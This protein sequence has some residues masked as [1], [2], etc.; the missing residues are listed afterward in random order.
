MNYAA[1]AGGERKG[2]ID[3]E[4]L[5]NDFHDRVYHWLY[6]MVR[7]AQDAEDMTICVFVQ[8]W[9]R[10]DRYDPSRSS[11]CT[12]LHLI[13]ETV[14]IAF[15]RKRRLWMSSLNE[16]PESREPTCAGPE[17]L[18]RAKEAGARLWRA[19]DRLPEPERDVV[20]AYYHDELSWAEV[21][22]KLRKCLRTVKFHAM[23]GLVLLRVIV[24]ADGVR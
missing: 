5:W 1:Q 10:Q 23:R 11:L 4:A 7:N 15:F 3:I 2:V 16:L 22:R 9:K 20:R 19:V 8:A 12:W 13:T 18:Y 24:L 14:A 17:E 6:R 21:A